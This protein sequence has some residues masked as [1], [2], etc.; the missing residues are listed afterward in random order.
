MTTMIEAEAITTIA[1]SPALLHAYT[2]QIDG[3]PHLMEYRSIRVITGRTL[4]RPVVEY[5]ESN[6]HTLVYESGYDDEMM[7]GYKGVAR[8]YRLD[9]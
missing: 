1:Y 7:A 5:L 4:D 8:L 2:V 3:V 9:N 6:P